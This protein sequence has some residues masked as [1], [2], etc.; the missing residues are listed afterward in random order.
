MGGEGDRDLPTGRPPSVDLRID[1]PHSARMYDYFLGGKD[2]FPADRQAAEAALS[3]F[4]SI[5]TTALQ[6]RKFMTRV[7]AELARSGVRQFLDIGTGIPTS[8]NLHEV[9]QRV[10]PDARIVYVDNDP[11]VLAHSRALLRSAPEGRTAYLEADL[12]EP[13]RIL[14]SAEVRETLDLSEP[15]ALSLFAI[16]HFVP[17]DVNPDGIVAELLDVLSP[18][19]YLALNHATPDFVTPEVE[20]QVTGLY[21]AQGIPFQSRRHAEIVRFFDGLELVDPGLVP[22]HQ[23]RPEGEPEDIPAADIA[24]YGGLARLTRRGPFL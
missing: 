10:A 13:E 17:D 20:A 6:A 8:P 22:V 12:R 1:T 7:T 16:L 3:I 4:P 23:W 15:V 2:N 9:A 21:R 19:S 14:R 11:I 5:R 24:S 18:G